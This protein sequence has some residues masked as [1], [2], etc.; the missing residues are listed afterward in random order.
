MSASN[1]EITFSG[2]P[3][4]RSPWPPAPV[5]HGPP[6]TPVPDGH[7][8]HTPVSDG[9][10]PHIPV[11][12]DPLLA[13]AS[14]GSQQA[15]DAGSLGWLTKLRAQIFVAHRAALHAQHALLEAATSPG[16]GA[17][18]TGPTAVM[19]HRP[20]A[21]RAR[22]LDDQWRSAD[23]GGTPAGL[24]LDGQVP[25][26]ALLDGLFQHTVIAGR[27][28]RRL[29][30]ATLI[31]RGELPLEE[32]A[33]RWEAG[34][35]QV[36]GA[37]ATF[38]A[39]CYTGG[40]PVLEVT[41]GRAGPAEAAGG[42]AGSPRS[43][44]YEAASF[45][46]LARTHKRSLDAEDI[47]L[48]AAGRIADVFGPGHR[49]EGC[50]PSLRLPG[51][52]RRIID[53]IDDIDAR[54]GRRGL[55]TLSA[56]GHVEASAAAPESLIIDGAAQLLQAYLLYLGGHLVLPDARFQPVTG[57]A[58]QITVTGPI[59]AETGALRY[60]AEVVELGLLDRP[61]AVADVT[62]YDGARKVM[63]I[64][65]IGVQIR[66]KP[67]TP[68]CPGP[69][70]RV[71]AFLGRTNQQ[72]ERALLNE[73]HMAHAAQGDLAVA[74]GPEFRIYQTSRA[75][76][77]PNGDFLFVDRMMDWRGDRGRL[78]PGATMITE[79][80][81]PP[82]AWYYQDNGHP[83]L[84]HCVLMETSLQSAVLL[85]YY[86][87][88]TLPYPD[89]QFSIRNLDGHAVVVKDVDLRGKTIRQ[90]S[91]LLSNDAMT[92]AVLQGFRYEL[93][94]DGEA[95]YTGE[96]LFGYFSEQALAGQAGLDA[97]RFVGPWHGDNGADAAGSVRRIDLREGAQRERLTA[98][99]GL[100]L[101]SGRLQ[102]IDWVDLIPG[103]G[104]HGAGYLRGYRRITPDEWYFSCH[105]HRDPVMPGSLGV[106]AILQ[107]MQLYA[108]ETGLAAGLD[109]PQFA[110]AAGVELGWRYR[111]QI[112][113]TDADMDFEVHIKEVRREPGRV[114]LVGDA[115]LWKPGLRIYELKNI[116]I[117]VVSGGRL[118]PP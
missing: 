74:M 83:F 79:Y 24:A 92:G 38:H 29:L 82:D 112:L 3:L 9:H 73:L 39:T 30:E 101:G 100:R 16:V 54:G 99:G 37:V 42:H 71:E 58:S 84:P 98:G 89:Q 2:E 51:R 43:R 113:R 44:S 1:D 81:S 117:A 118:T 32:E 111:G 64:H 67:G 105:F 116:A 114:L 106:E 21:I 8:P 109:R 18:G 90:H 96:S 104:E 48:L 40:T 34:V 63:A 85:G 53:R 22:P 93:T 25:I 50:N 78:V 68:Y 65:D 70:G 76:Y 31:F 60:E 6:H 20:A 23:G 103:G 17:G 41:G 72:G 91:T 4:D 15:P 61:H 46:P 35:D 45:R 94:A 62:V 102:L 14:D 27:P 5:P 69:G 19:A 13:A 110:L 7:P 26:A 59:P 108:I 33:V 28:G 47:A 88:A 86:L 57:R 115:N 107:A 97:G 87:G 95:F 10:P 52:R 66:E 49:Q 36:V 11:P 55:G 77:I 75:P 12:P 56:A 80:D